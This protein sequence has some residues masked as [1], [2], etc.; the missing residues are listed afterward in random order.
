MDIIIE[1]S[2]PSCGAPIALHETDRLVE[3]PYCEVKNYMI[4]RGPARFVLPDKIPAH[5]SREELIFAPYLRFKGN[6][7]YCQGFEVEHAVIDTTRLALDSEKLPTSLGLRPQAMRVVPVNAS[8][9]GRFARQALKPETLFDQAV[10][11]TSLFAPEQKKELYHRAFIGET[12]SR[13]YLPLYI[14]G[15]C[16]VD[17]VTNLELGPAGSIWAELLERSVPF[18][19][20]WEPRFLSTLCPRCAA[21]MTGEPDALVL[22]CPN[23]QT[24]WEEN[25]GKFLPL[26]WQNIDG[27]DD[28]VL[29]IPF[30]RITLQVLGS[31]ILRTF[32]DFLRLTNQPVLVKTE[33]EG[34]PLSFW[35]PA[36][37]L[38]PA[39]FLQVAHYLTVSQRRIPPAGASEISCRSYPVNLARQEAVQALK[40]V[41]AAATLSKKKVLPLLAS[42]KMLPEKTSLIFLPF[43]DAGH[44]MI[45][46]HTSVVIN[47]AALR[48]GRKL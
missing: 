9:T 16:L 48:F 41:V 32:A 39:L 22:H 12:L 47:S 24:M 31:G 5:V 27:G 36:F 15:D 2:C 46:S 26:D 29:A 40:S 3:C 21:P 23:C 34:L 1:Q 42:L 28:G 18:Q 45:Q 38:T 6:L 35:I 33:Y 8:H 43:R 37:K 4:G 19:S 14:Q 13:I 7:Y 11:M 44:D 30:W 25:E 17:G 20:E 10:K